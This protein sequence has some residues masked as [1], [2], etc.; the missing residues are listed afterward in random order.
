[1]ASDSWPARM[2]ADECLVPRFWRR[3]G[4]D[5]NVFKTF[6]GRR[7]LQ[8]GEYVADRLLGHHFVL[9]PQCIAREAAL[10]GRLKPRQSGPEFERPD[11]FQNTRPLAAL[12]EDGV[13]EDVGRLL[14]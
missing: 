2:V 6:L 5:Q 14:G 12:D 9:R 7:W 8:G 10:Q 4:N 3:S 13:E 1:M 11:D